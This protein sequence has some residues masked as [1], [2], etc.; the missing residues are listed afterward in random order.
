V[1]R[2]ANNRDISHLS[3]EQT[4]S[5]TIIAPKD[6]FIINLEQNWPY[7][8]NRPLQCLYNGA[9]IWEAPRLLKP[10]YSDHVISK[11]MQEIDRQ[12]LYKIYEVTVVHYGYGREEV[13][14]KML[15]GLIVS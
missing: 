8:S 5:I 10:M 15:N 2:T 9:P 14:L 3:G 7:G 1:N 4:S 12:G 6:V 11:I 13:T